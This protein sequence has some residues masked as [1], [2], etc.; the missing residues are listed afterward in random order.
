MKKTFNMTPISTV[1]PFHSFIHELSINIK[2]MMFQVKKNIMMIKY[3][4]KQFEVIFLIMI[5]N[6]IFNL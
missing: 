2:Q 6:M 4:L 1:L 3:D 5:F